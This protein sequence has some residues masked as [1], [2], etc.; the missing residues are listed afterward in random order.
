MAS[1]GAAR[2]LRVIVTGMHRSGTSL[3]AELVHRWGA[4]AGDPQEL[5]DADEIN[6]RGYWE[7]WPLMRLN[8]ALLDAAEGSWDCPP[9]DAAAVRALADD[10]TLASWARREVA[11]MDRRAERWVWKDPRFAL[12]MPFWQRWLHDASYLVPI[13]HPLE[14]ARS[15]WHRDRIPLTAG[16]LLWQLSM[17]RLLE[18]T[19]GRPCYFVDHDALLRDPAREVRRLAAWLD[20]LHGEPSSEGTRNEMARAVD[21]KLH[22]QRAARPFEDE[23]LATEDQRALWRA[24]AEAARCASDVSVDPSAVA[25]YPGWRD[26]LEA[27]R[28]RRRHAELEDREAALLERER[29][30]RELEEELMLLLGRAPG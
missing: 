13:R 16:L 8:D 10:P 9:R 22:R 17:L 20:D 12:L 2:P 25:P 29:R 27:V 5:M 3:V 4:D 18:S 7:R 21:P 6:P 1:P 24:L 23:P 19:R 30:L 15:L 28:A 11:S 14:S 26:Y